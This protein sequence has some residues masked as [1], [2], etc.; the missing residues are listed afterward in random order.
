MVFVI[1][2]GITHNSNGLKTDQWCLFL[3]IR[4]YTQNANTEVTLITEIWQFGR[5]EDNTLPSNRMGV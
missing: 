4:H 3:R 5:R 2:Y 1:N